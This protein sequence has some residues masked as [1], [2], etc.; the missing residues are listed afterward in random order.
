MKTPDGK[1][2]LKLTIFLTLT[3]LVLIA[4]H[5]GRIWQ[6]HAEDARNDAQRRDLKARVYKRV[7]II[8]EIAR[9]KE[10]AGNLSCQNQYPNALKAM[11]EE[12]RA[13]AQPKHDA[14]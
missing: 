6:M 10:C 11:K 8:K 7:L 9:Y 14:P 2:S 4:G 5:F 1:R 13:A 3:L 12:E